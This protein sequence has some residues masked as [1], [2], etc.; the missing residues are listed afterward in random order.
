MNTFVI[1]EAGA[2]HNKNFN[3]AL[4]LIDV[5]V[6]SGA[7]ACK[8][9]TYSSNNHKC[10]LDLLFTSSYSIIM[11]TIKIL[12]LD[13]S[14]YIA[15]PAYF[16]CINKLL[17]PQ[18]IIDILDYLYTNDTNIFNY[19]DDMGY[20]ISYLIVLLDNFELIKYIIKKCGTLLDKYSPLT[21]KHIFNISYIISNSLRCYFFG[22]G[23]IRISTF[24]CCFSL[25]LKSF[26][27]LRVL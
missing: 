27:R 3:Q 5:A 1:A 16:N 20:N 21:T 6:E 2:N 7:S 17:K 13:Y 15:H 22:S 9:Q 19:V 23:F 8:F 4:S 18:Y 11:K 14:N 24:I 12:N 26:L 25:L 10:C